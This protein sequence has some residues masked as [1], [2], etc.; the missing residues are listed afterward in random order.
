MNYNLVPANVA[1]AVLPN[2]NRL[3]RNLANA[4]QQH[5]DERIDRR[6][7]HRDE[8]KKT[9]KG[10]LHEAPKDTLDR[11]PIFSSSS[12]WCRRRDDPSA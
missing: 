1:A 12:I 3:P 2:R 9:A 11:S 10:A 4:Q 7:F 8:M 5:N 6:Q